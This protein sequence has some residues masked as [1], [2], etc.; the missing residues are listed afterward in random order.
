[1]TFRAWGDIPTWGLFAAVVTAIFAILAFRKQSQE[2]S[3]LERQA[4][5]QRK[6]TRQQSELLKIQSE[7]LD[8]QRKQAEEQRAVIARQSDILELQAQ[9][10]KASIEQRERETVTAKDLKPGDQSQRNR[11]SASQHESKEKPIL[12]NRFRPAIYITAVGVVGAL[13][14]LLIDWP[15]FVGLYQINPALWVNLTVFLFPL[16]YVVINRTV[17]MST[18]E[19]LISFIL[20]LFYGSVLWLQITLEVFLR[21]NLEVAKKLDYLQGHFYDLFAI[22]AIVGAVGYLLVHRSTI[23]RMVT[24]GAVFALTGAISGF[25]EAE[26]LSTNKVWPGYQ[27]WALPI[28]W[29]LTGIWFGICVGFLTPELRL[30]QAFSRAKE[31]NPSYV[32]VSAEIACE[33]GTFRKVGQLM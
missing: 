16:G 21:T 15:P 7:Q 22:A 30:T 28:L 13:G 33:L 5:D 27:Y 11:H 29:A 25:V 8:L 12:H 19:T 32:G 23:I 20:G 9:E 14:G 6:L 2:V 10:L 26:V 4:Q 17:K 24:F 1:M 3:T 18:S 31:L